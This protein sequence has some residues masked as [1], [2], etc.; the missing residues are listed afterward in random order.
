MVASRSSSPTSKMFCAATH[1]TKPDAPGHPGGRSSRFWVSFNRRL[2]RV[3]VLTFDGNRGCLLRMRLAR[4]TV[5]RPTMSQRC[6][7]IL[8]GLEP[9]IDL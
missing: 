4:E 9:T 3:A 6:A 2:P 1:Q 7:P 8:I 5:E